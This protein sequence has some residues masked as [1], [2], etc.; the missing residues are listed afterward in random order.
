M[1]E[2][3]P[4]TLAGKIRPGDTVRHDKGEALVTGTKRAPGRKPP[5]GENIVLL[6]KRGELRV[7]SLAPIRVRRG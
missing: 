5:K 6:T 7:N 1:P 4:V 2:K 3:L